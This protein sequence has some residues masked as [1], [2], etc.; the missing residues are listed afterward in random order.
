MAG[1]NAVEYAGFKK[2]T[3][4]VLD[5]SEYSTVVL[6]LRERK[7]S[8]T[9]VP[10]AM[11]VT[12]EAPAAVPSYSIPSGATALT[13]ANTTFHRHD[14]VYSNGQFV[15]HNSAPLSHT[16]GGIKFQ[17]AGYTTLSFTVTTKSSAMYVNIECNNSVPWHTT[18]APNTTETHVVDITGLT[19]VGFRTFTAGGFCDSVITNAYV[20]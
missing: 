8:E 5:V 10:T 3:E 12:L 18:Q 6:K 15:R 4:V 13:D 1:N 20:E 16:P 17:N 19:A 9:D 2:G 14:T 11:T 7:P